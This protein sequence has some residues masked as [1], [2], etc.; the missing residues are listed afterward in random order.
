LHGVPPGKDSAL[1]PVTAEKA[2]AI[3]ASISLHTPVQILLNDSNSFVSESKSFACAYRHQ[4]VN[5]SSGLP[6]NSLQH[7]RLSESGKGGAA[8]ATILIVESYAK[9]ATTTKYRFGIYKIRDFR[10]YC[11]I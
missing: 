7:P 4:Y 1:P 10:K 11:R 2:P 6:N 3:P 8:M 9:S 5:L